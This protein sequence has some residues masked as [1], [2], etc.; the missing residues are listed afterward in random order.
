MS[1]EE[2]RP[3]T[4]DTMMRPRAAFSTEDFSL[5]RTAVLHYLKE[6]Q[7]K[8]ESVKY[9]ALYHRLGRIEG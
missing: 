3:M 5:M 9:A 4:T 7:D 8:P 2:D 1:D 6:V